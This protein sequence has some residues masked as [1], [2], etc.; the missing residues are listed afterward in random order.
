M[1]HLC[2][3]CFSVSQTCKCARLLTVATPVLKA[4]VHSKADVHDAISAHM[5]GTEAQTKPTCVENIKQSQDQ[6]GNS[7]PQQHTL[8][9]VSGPQNSQRRE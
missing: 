8:I 9:T 5:I 7:P 2:C 6:P 4:T 3:L 1:L